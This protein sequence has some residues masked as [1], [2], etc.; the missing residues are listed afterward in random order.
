MK[1]C[2]ICGN[3]TKFKKAVEDALAGR[4]ESIEALATKIGKTL[5]EIEVPEDLPMDKLIQR[6]VSSGRYRPI[7]LEAIIGASAKKS[8]KAKKKKKSKE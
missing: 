1:K 3:D 4:A 8:K 5:R 7:L 2:P 6:I